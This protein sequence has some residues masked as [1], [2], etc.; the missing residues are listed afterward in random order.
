MASSMAPLHS[1]GQDDP[2]HSKG[3]DDQ[4]EVQHDFLV[5]VSVSKDTTGTGVGVM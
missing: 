5:L 4:N 3:Q 1:I 2:S